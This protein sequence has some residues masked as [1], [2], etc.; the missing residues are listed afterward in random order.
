MLDRLTDDQ[1]KVLLIWLFIGI[2]LVIL[3]FVIS[4]IHGGFN[5][6][7]KDERDKSYKIVKDYNKYYTVINIVDK[8]YSALNYDYSKNLVEMLNEDY[9]NE[10]NITVDNVISKLKKGS[11]NVTYQ[12][13]LMCKKSLHTGIISYYISGEEVGSNT[14]EILGD[15]YFEVLLDENNMTFN[16]KEI[17]KISFGDECHE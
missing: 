5:I 4:N 16:I 8:Y 12:G 17:D 9:K 11:I 10:N 13:G 6:L 15:K 14:G 3:F 7:K 1:R 2:F